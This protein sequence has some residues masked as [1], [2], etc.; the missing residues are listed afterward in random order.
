MLRNE[1]FPSYEKDPSTISGRQKFKKI[2]LN[3]RAAFKI[4]TN[5]DLL[6]LV[7]LL[8]HWNKKSRKTKDEP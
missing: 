6:K 7:Y 1:A 8:I 3:S 2:V 4:C 5:I